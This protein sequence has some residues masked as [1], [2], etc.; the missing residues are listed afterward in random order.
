M[1]GLFSTAYIFDLTNNESDQIVSD[2]HIEEF[3][4]ANKS[5][6]VQDLLNGM[7][8]LI[9][10]SD[11][12]KSLLEFLDV[13]TISERLHG[14]NFLNHECKDNNEGWIRVLLL[15]VSYD[16]AEKI[17]QF[18][19][20]TYPVDQEIEK[21]KLIKQLSEKDSLTGLYNRSSYE[22]ELQILTES[23]LRD[24]LVVVKF[25]LNELKSVND[26]HGYAAGDEIIIGL[27]DC[28]KQTFAE[29]GKI[30]RIGGDEFIAIINV[31]LSQIDDLLQKFETHVADWKGKIVKDFSVSKGYASISGNPELTI[32]D[33]E[34]QADK[35]MYSDKSEFHKHS[36]MLHQDKKLNSAAING[37]L[38][39]ENIGI[40]SIEI[41][42]NQPPRMY[43][44]KIMKLL[45]GVTGDLSPENTYQ[46]W[47]DRIHPD[48][49]DAVTDSV[50]KMII[51]NH[52]EVQ[53]PWTH[54]EKGKIFVRC[55][56]VRD[57]KYKNGIRLTGSHQN[58]TNIIHLNKDT[59]TDLYTREFFYQRAQNILKENP[60]RDFTFFVVNIENFK[61]VNEK[62][63]VEGGD[64]LLKHVATFVTRSFP[65]LV[66]S[67]RLS[68]DRFICMQDPIEIDDEKG[69]SL[70]LKMLERMPFP[71]I[72]IKYGLYHTKF[73]RN[74]SVQTMCDRANIAVNSIKGVYKVKQATYDE[75]L[76]NKIHK[77]Q[78]IIDNMKA[79][80]E[81]EE[82]K[83]YL[84]PKHNLRT[85]K[86]GGAEALIRWIHP[87]LGFMN[88]GDFIPL[89]E[90]NGFIK[91]VDEY[92]FFKVLEILKS[93]LDRKLRVVPISINL[94][95]RDFEHENFAENIS[96]A[97]DK[98]GIPHNL[99][100]FE[101]TESAISDNPDL[102]IKNLTEL[103]NE[104]Y[105]IELDD[106]GA[107][108]AS[109]MT[110]SEIEF[111]ILKL[112]MSIIKNDNPT[113]KRNA[114]DIC[115]RISKDMNLISV[116]EGIETEEQVV[117][118]KN[119]GCDFI[120]G[121]FYSKPLPVEEFEKYLM[122]N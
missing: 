100:H 54:P 122:D 11:S 94:S 22:K 62:Y 1:A 6:S 83:I 80:I 53:Y 36:E 120:Q 109:L 27:A 58:V 49:Y 19:F 8:K 60:N 99:I 24:D 116:A 91:K 104:G 31:P 59:L 72:N 39:R 92:V 50:E 89:F 37:I 33:L 41:D 55:G 68:G 23:G 38:E 69:D 28:L 63:G 9:A 42:E 88:P 47:Y 48:Y 25:D 61:L 20:V 34:R 81:N 66:I 35:R 111:D 106:F 78:N 119:L 2:S 82:F 14:K 52:A 26:A 110:L 5:L 70:E 10:A 64:K 17:R 93:W 105:M 101:L 30:F 112:D 79:G 103:H 84:Q 3:Y 18:I 98:Y 21:E 51:G 65:N 95:R 85:N 108:Y 75:E 74:I 46:F 71:N 121:Y 90:S 16:E 113:S 56:G 97:V 102:I 76:Q 29:F 115:S 43:A 96:K 40:W 7:A 77:N 86:T 45:L 15:P 4:S 117:R 114:L 12:L 107:G 67:G 118:I 73:D 87:E 44:D 32:N 13:S 57:T